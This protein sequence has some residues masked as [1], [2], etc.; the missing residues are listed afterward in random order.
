[1]ATGTVKWFSDAKGF[2]FIT[3]DDGSEDLFAHFSAI[4]MS[5][6]KSLKESQKVTF[7]VVIQ[8]VNGKKRRQAS[9][10]QLAEETISPTILPSKSTAPCE[11]NSLEWSNSIFY[12]PLDFEKQGSLPLPESGPLPENAIALFHSAS[13]D[14]SRDKILDLPT[15]SPPSRYSFLDA[16]LTWRSE[17]GNILVGGE[18]LAVKE[19]DKVVWRNPKLLDAVYSTLKKLDNPVAITSS[20]HQQKIIFGPPG[21]GKSYS[22]RNSA[23]ALGLLKNDD[24]VDAIRT[25]FHPEY[26]YGDFVAK[27]LPLTVK[28]I[29][30]GD[31][32]KPIEKTRVEYQIHAGPFIQALAQAL[33]DKDNNVLLVIEE[34]NRGNCA[35]IFGDIFQL[36]DRNNSGESDYQIDPSKLIR[37]ALKQELE[38]KTAR[39]ENEAKIIVAKEFRIPANLSIVATM[40]TSDESVFYMDSAF[41]RRWQ[42]EY[43][44]P[45][46]H[47][48]NLTCPQQNAIIMSKSAPNKSEAFKIGSDDLTWETLRKAI[49]K[50]LLDNSASVRRIEDK[51]IGL[52]FIK[53]KDREIAHEDIKFKLMHYLWDNVFARDKSPLLNKLELKKEELVTFGQFADKCDEFIKKICSL[54]EAVPIQRAGTIAKAEA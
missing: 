22:V 4:N 37:L 6:F 1:M 44:G 49:N 15:S 31:D 10:I 7:D 45:D 54:P 2:G 21:T 28:E 13:Q 14:A 51:Q 11:D 52:W 24:N 26:S 8:E 32:G 43:I 30:I 29:S 19:G 33:A 16:T 25:T 38:N 41:K 36:L 35:A 39:S 9:N 3:P 40:N 18:I 50:F 17:N 53:A 48:E 23:A 12:V 47:N 46:D 27:L 42:F 5:G 20:S 34:I